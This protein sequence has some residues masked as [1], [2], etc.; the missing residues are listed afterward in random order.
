[1]ERL[2]WPDDDRSL[3]F[4]VVKDVLQQDGVVRSV[5]PSVRHADDR[6]PAAIVHPGTLRPGGWPAERFARAADG[7]A[8][9]GMRL[10]LTGIGGAGERVAATRVLRRSAGS[11]TDLVGRT[12]VDDLA[13][14]M[15]RAAIV[16]TADAGAACLAA[17]LR[18][19]S[20]VVCGSSEVSRWAFL[21][22]RLHRVVSGSAAEAVA[23]AKRVMRL[24]A[25]A[26]A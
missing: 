4:P 13:E 10:L 2:G 3:E 7:L 24:P 1:M 19:P 25:H 8:A 21:D 26:A 20:V 15:R 14:L 12:G 5:F 22:R 6:V 18:V 16:L 9:D 17:A 23:Q 11:F